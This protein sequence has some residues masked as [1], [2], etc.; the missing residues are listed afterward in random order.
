[1]GEMIASESVPVKQP[2]LP[3][4]GRIPSSSGKAN[5]CRGCMASSSSFLG[6][7]SFCVAAIVLLGF[8]V[9]AFAFAKPPELSAIEVYP[10]GDSQA[11]VQISG[12]ALNG[13]I[14]VHLCGGVQTISKSNYSKLPKIDLAAGMSLERKKDGVLLLSHEGKLDCIV[15]GNLKLEKAE[16][17]TPAELAERA[18]L[19]GQIASKS[20]STTESIP[21]LTP[22]VK[23]VLVDTLNTE[24][25]E[26]LLAQRGGTIASWEG[27]L[28]KYPSGPHS[29]EAKA[30]LSS[31]YVQDGQT[32][33]TAYRA[34]LS[35]PQP[36]YAK[37]QAAKSALDYAM[38]R[39]PSNS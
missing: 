36:N 29:G 25:A 38:A 34:S 21:R 1:M 28:G 6:K 12:F 2:N 4:F 22:G 33:L 17:E 5:L 26:F 31:L 24:L 3:P 23:I 18:D 7:A 19:S 10:I 11:Y 8:S 37:L 30:A 35:D 13:K 39:A 16:G 20:V 9:P 32:A 27:Y 14:E 15:P